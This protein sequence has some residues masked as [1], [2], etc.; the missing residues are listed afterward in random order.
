MPP[1]TRRSPIREFAAGFG[2]FFAGFAYW[3]RRPLLMLLGLLPAA[4]VGIVLAGLLIL[5]GLNLG[6]ISEWAT[7][8]ADNWEAIWVVALWLGP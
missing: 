2:H 4:I 1:R 6:R 5:L 8:F 7:P 3:K